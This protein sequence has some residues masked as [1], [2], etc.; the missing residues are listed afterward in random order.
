MNWRQ[1]QVGKPG[2]FF[3]CHINGIFPTPYLTACS[4]KNGF[5]LVPF[6][7]QLA[8]EPAKCKQGC[9]HLQVIFIIVLTTSMYNFQVCGRTGVHGA[10]VQRLVEWERVLEFV[11]VTV[12]SVVVSGQRKRPHA[13]CKTV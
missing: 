10:H 2:H 11:Y 8:V 6:L 13:N 5:Y 3:V 4:R 12:E 1:A 7:F 9:D